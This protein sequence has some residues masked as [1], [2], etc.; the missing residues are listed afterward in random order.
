[1]GTSGPGEVGVCMRREGRSRVFLLI[2]AAV[3]FTCPRIAQANAGITSD[4]VF[5]GIQYSSNVLLWLL[6]AMSMCIGVEAAIYA[7]A[8]CVRNPIRT[9]AIANTVSLIAGIPLALLFALLADGFEIYDS[10]FVLVVLP[11]LVSIGIE[12]FVVSWRAKPGI[13]HRRLRA[14]AVAIVANVLTNII[15]AFYLYVGFRRGG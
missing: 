2:A 3:F 6:A 8:G 9:S 4:L 1:M 5:Q 14:W 13:P 10:V 11:T 15:L 7:Y 12:G